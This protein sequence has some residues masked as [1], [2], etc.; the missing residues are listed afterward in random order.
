MNLAKTFGQIKSYEGDIA[1]AARREQIARQSME[2]ARARLTNSERDLTAARNRARDIGAEISRTETTIVN[3]SSVLATTR[4]S[5]QPLQ[6]LIGDLLD[7]LNEAKGVDLADQR[8]RALRKLAGIAGDVDA[9][10]ERGRT[11]ATHADG[12]LGAGWMKSC[13]AS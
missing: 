1:A 3:V 8:P 12:T 6:I 7:A 11:A 10:I 5:I 2:S 13:K 4:A 9:A